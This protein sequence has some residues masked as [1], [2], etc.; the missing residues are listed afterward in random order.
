MTGGSR[1]IGEA[2]ALGLAAAGLDVAVL[3]RSTERLEGVAG[4][5]RSLGARAGAVTADITDPAQVLRAVERAEAEVG[6]IDLLVN[7]AGVIEPTEQPV[8]QEDPAVWRQ[9]VEADLLGPM[10]AVR[11][12][13]PGMVERGLGR[14]VDLSSGAGTAARTEYTAYCA[15]KTGLMRLSGHLHLAGHD[16]GLRAFEISPGVV[17]TE[18]TA[19]MATHTGRS[20]WTPTEAIVDLVVAVARGSLDAWSGRFLR[21]GVDTVDSLTAAGRAG[22]DDSA[23]TLTVVP[24]GPEDPLATT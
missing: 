17:A 14:V 4:R 16:L 9:V 11:A 18:M 1:G 23:R 15:A 10:Y 22:L 3:G 2:L 6:P 19:A 5:L 24:Y 8:W 20:E 13:V 21:A 12:V 7:N